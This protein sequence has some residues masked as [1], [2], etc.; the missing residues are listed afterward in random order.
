MITEQILDCDWRLWGVQEGS[1]DKD[2]VSG[3][4]YNGAVFTNVDSVST[5][6]S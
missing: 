3:L 4:R 6:G 1:G 2:S 5:A